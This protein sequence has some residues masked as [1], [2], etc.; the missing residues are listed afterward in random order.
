MSP[1]RDRAEWPPVTDRQI[2]RE[3][4]RDTTVRYNEDRFAEIEQHRLTARRSGCRERSRARSWLS[5]PP[6]ITQ[7]LS[8]R[9]IARLNTLRS[10]RGVPFVVYGSEP[11]LGRPEVRPQPAIRACFDR[12]SILA[13]FAVFVA[14]TKELS[15][16]PKRIRCR[17]LPSPSP[18]GRCTVQLRTDWALTSERAF[19][20]P[21][22][23]TC[24]IV[25]F[26]GADVIRSRY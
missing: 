24:G 26:G 18:S 3:R 20:K 5:L 13:D 2:S 9:I 8:H 10:E 17:T 6:R 22:A 12:Y 19:S 21:L 25:V 4:F 16:F 23:G 15:V 1:R 14:S 7:L 11:G